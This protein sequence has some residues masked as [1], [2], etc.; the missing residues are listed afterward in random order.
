M[1]R[2]YSRGSKDILCFRQDMRSQERRQRLDSNKLDC[3]AEACLE[4]LGQ[5]EKTVVSLGS[6]KELDQE[7]DITV[8]TSLTAC[9]AA[10]QCEPPHTKYTD[11]RRRRNKPF[12]CLLSSKRGCLHTI[13]SLAGSCLPCQFHRQPARPAARIRGIDPALLPGPCPFRELSQEQIRVGSKAASRSF[14]FHEK[15]RWSLQPYVLRRCAS[16]FPAS[17]WMPCGGMG[18]RPGGM[19]L[20]RKGIRVMIYRTVQSGFVWLCVKRSC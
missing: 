13:T 1:W 10:E 14:R 7:I 3:A 20:G 15:A 11:L 18:R 9:Y 19:L 16:T 17:L 8:A 6:R 2:R 12:N 5:R 4:Q